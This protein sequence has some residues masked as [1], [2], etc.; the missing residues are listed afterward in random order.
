MPQVMKIAKILGPRKMMPN[1]KSGTVVQ[2]LQQ[3]I[4]DAKGGTFASTDAANRC[5]YEINHLA[6][7][8][9]HTLVHTEAV[10]VSVIRYGII[11]AQSVYIH[12]YVCTYVYVYMYVLCIH[13]SHQW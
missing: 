8:G 3:A 1:P 5:K 6:S 10:N 13:I 11:R 9:Q 4:K 12:V 7:N 2:N